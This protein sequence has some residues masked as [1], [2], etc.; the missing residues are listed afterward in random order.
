MGAAFSSCCCCSP[1]VKKYAGFKEHA[2]RLLFPFEDKFPG[3]TPDL[4]TILPSG[5]IENSKTLEAEKERGLIAYTHAQFVEPSVAQKIV[6]NP[7]SSWNTKAYS[8]TP[9]VTTSGGLVQTWPTRFNAKFKE[10]FERTEATTDT[11][12]F[13]PGAVQAFKTCM[14][15]LFGAGAT[16]KTP[17]QYCHKVTTNNFPCYVGLT[18]NLKDHLQKNPAEMAE[19]GIKELTADGFISTGRDGKNNL[20]EKPFKMEKNTQYVIYKKNGWTIMG[21]CKTLQQFNK[22]CEFL[23]EPAFE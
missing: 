10:E 14:E 6:D 12:H 21:C 13:E 15:T 22:E 2:Y 8:E 11:T 3:M 18:E 7:E 17:I 23:G 20:V 1:K 9:F 16:N 19:V 5:V 4:L